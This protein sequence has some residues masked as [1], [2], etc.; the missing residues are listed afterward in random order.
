VVFSGDTAYLPRLAGFAQGADLLS[1]EA[2]LAEARA[3]LMDSSR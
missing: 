1:H 3:L 2:M